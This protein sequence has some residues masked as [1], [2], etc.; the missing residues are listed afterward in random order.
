MNVMVR[1]A[2]TAALIAPVVAAPA[3]AQQY[4]VDF[5]LN[6]GY[7]W[8]SA[9]LG[10]DETGV[11]DAD[12]RFNANWL[13][14]SQLTF[15]VTPKIGL[16]ANM[17]YTDTDL[18][19]AD[20]TNHEHINLWSGTGDL[21]FRFREP[22][23][24]W[25][26]AETLPY[27]ALGI[28]GKWHNPASDPFMCRDNEEGEEQSCHPFTIGTRGFA[29]AEQ[30]TLAGLVGLGAD[31]RVT[32]NM[33]I[34]AEI[35]DRIY[36]PKIY[37]V[38]APATGNTWTMTAG[39]DNA[40]K[41][42]HEIGAQIGLHILAGLAAPPVVAVAPAPPPPAPTPAP[43]PAPPREEAI[44]VCVIDPTVP[45]GYRMQSATYLVASGDTVVTTNGQRVPL[46]TAVGNVVVA[47]G[48]NWYV[49]GAPL[50]VTVGNDNYEYLTYQGARQIDAN[51]LTFLGTVDGM[52]VY[53][54][55]DQ[56]ADVRDQLADVREARGTGDLEDILDEEDDLREAIDAVQIV[57]APLQPTGCVF[58]ALQ[59][60]QQVRKG[61]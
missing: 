53:A 7:S 31:F 47:G 38:T 27:L 32:P 34:R 10:D 50:T 2:L 48:Q 57:Y 4:K 8:Y 54:D 18:N 40:S 58:Q 5:G 17:T 16:R 43:T 12:V 55:R 25:M 3:S 33:A 35:N 44:T 36:K 22:N 23:E 61:K 20:V 9:A 28:G 39:D 24:E 30:K 15:W 45:A 60:Q 52:P 49:S 37:A 11:E 29:L 56:V 26:G 42:V 21:M 1:A 13:L 6:G 51:R 46:R 14:G 19:V 41:V 59:R